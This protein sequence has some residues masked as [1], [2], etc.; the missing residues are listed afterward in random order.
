M[1]VYVSLHLMCGPHYLK[2]VKACDVSFR[3]GQ[4][5]RE[6]EKTG[7]IFD[8]QGQLVAGMT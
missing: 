7:L 2:N 3:G 6:I 5:V 1:L 8:I 4:K